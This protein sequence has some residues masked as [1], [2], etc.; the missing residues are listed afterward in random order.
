VPLSVW[1][2]R[3]KMEVEEAMQ[4]LGDYHGRETALYLAPGW[5]QR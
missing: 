1:M 3:V 5:H 4:E 2:G